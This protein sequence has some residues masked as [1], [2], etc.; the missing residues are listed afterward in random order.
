[1]K[2]RFWQSRDGKIEKNFCRGTKKPDKI[3]SS[4]AKIFILEHIVTLNK[5]YNKPQN[6][7]N[8][9]RLFLIKAL[10]AFGYS[11]SLLKGGLAVHL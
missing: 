8:G 2:I 9:E 1:L 7:H 3:K 11:Y 5:P 6:S 4:R 10:F